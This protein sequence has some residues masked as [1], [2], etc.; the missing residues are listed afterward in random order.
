MDAPALAALA[1][2]TFSDKVRAFQGHAWL[3]DRTRDTPRETMETRKAMD[4]ARVEA[5]NALR[6]L[7]QLV[8]AELAAL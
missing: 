5:R 7:E 2:N 4:S 1:F 8:R 3:Y 6:A